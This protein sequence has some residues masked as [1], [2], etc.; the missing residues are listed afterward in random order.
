MKQVRAVEVG[1]DNIKLREVDEVFDVPNDWN[2]PWFVDVNAPVVPKK[3]QGQTL[4]AT[5]LSGL[6]KENADNLV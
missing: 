6:Q 1:Y 4:S 5:T 3:T 2:A